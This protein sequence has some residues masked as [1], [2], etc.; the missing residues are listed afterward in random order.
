MP[1]GCP[2][3]LRMYVMYVCCARMYVMYVCYT[4]IP[5]GTS[6]T[7]QKVLQCYR[8]Y[9]NILELHIHTLRSYTYTYNTGSIFD[10]C[11]LLVRY[12]RYTGVLASY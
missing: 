5:L 7:I 3:R 8:R 2:D 10:S 12:T 11:S 6:T 9:S 1:D 4:I